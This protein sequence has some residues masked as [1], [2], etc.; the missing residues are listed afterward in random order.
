M[1]TVEEV[2]TRVIEDRTI[3]GEVSRT[4]RSGD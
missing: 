3:S 2:L 1:N 4:G